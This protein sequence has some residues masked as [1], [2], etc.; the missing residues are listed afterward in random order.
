MDMI[1]S[2]NKIADS[3]SQAAAQYEKYASIQRYSASSIGSV[4]ASIIDQLPTGP[5]MEIGCGTGTLSRIL[6]NELPDRPLRLTDF[7]A[8]ML[9]QCNQNIAEL[10]NIKRVTWHLQDGEEITDQSKFALIVS[11]LTMQWFREPE[12]ALLR[13][14]Q[15]LKP[16]GALLYS[17]IGRQSFPQWRIMCNKLDLPCTVNLFPNIEKLQKKIKPAFKKIDVWNESIDITYKNVSD[18]FNFMKKSGTNTSVLGQSLSLIQ[19][20]RLLNHWHKELAGESLTMTYIIQ[21]IKAVK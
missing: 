7:A 15:A 1:D 21:Y 17:T 6:I 3:F 12:Q 20:R 16:G 8:G 10:P 11:G 2:K 18:F 9:E 14:G 13:T 19:M 4:I 5:V